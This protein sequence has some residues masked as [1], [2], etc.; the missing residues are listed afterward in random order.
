MGGYDL[1]SAVIQGA[2]RES[3]SLALMAL[4]RALGDSPGF[5]GD[6]R[7]L[8]AVLTPVGAVPTSVLRRGSTVNNAMP[9]SVFEPGSPLQQRV[10][11]SGK[12]P[13]FLE[14]LLTRFQREPAHVPSE[15][16]Q[17]TLTTALT[18]PAFLAEAQ[19]LTYRGL[20]QRVFFAPGGS[21]LEPLSVKTFLTL[22]IRSG[23]PSGLSE[24]AWA[25]LEAMAQ[26]APDQP[27]LTDHMV[28]AKARKTFGMTTADTMER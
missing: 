7:N 5:S 9:F 19:R 3:R 13:G 2:I 16:A 15:W 18:A 10:L 12:D 14:R 1:S 21:P 20:R 8:T 26:Q 22:I 24:Q 11:A 6:M 4:A 23:R 28:L 25:R 27:G 17:A